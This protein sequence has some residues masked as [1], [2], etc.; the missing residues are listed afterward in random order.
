MIRYVD[1]LQTNHPPKVNALSSHSYRSLAVVTFKRYC[2]GNLQVYDPVLV[3]QL[4]RICLPS[5]RLWGLIPGSGRCPGEGNGSP[6]QCSCL[7]NPMDRGA[8]GVTVH[9]VAKSR[10]WQTDYTTATTKKIFSSVQSLSCVH[11]FATPWTG[12]HA[13]LLCP[14]P[15]PRACS[16]S[17]PLSRWCHPTISSFAVP[18]SSCPQSFPASE[19]FPMSRF[20][21]SGGQSIGVSASALVLPM[22]IQDQFPLGWTGW[23]SL[24]SRGLSRVFSNTTVQK[25]HF[26]HAQLYLYY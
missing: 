11:L 8:W 16:K 5:S 7:E 3:P 17:C 9:G 4:W 26:F 1:M 2:L 21:A 13:R 20:F 22:N 15:S 6:L 12:Q 10:T 18:F 24:Q 19:S 23:I 14:S 25:H